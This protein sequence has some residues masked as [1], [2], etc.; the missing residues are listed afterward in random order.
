M[1]IERKNLVVVGLAIIIL[2]VPIAIYVFSFRDFGISRDNEDWANFGSYLAGTYTL[3]ASLA[4]VAT[5]L[6][7]LYQHYGQKDQQDRLSLAQ[8]EIINFQKYQAHYQQ[9]LQLIESVEQDERYCV[10]IINKSALYKEL[11]PE[12]S[13]AECSYVINL[14]DKDD[15]YL[16][17]DIK[18][19][20]PRLKEMFRSVEVS[21]NQAEQIVDSLSRLYDTFYLKLDRPEQ[22][23]DIVFHVDN[24]SRHIILNTDNLKEVSS[25]LWAVLDVLF[26]FSDN[27]APEDITY[28]VG[29]SFTKNSMELYKKHI[30][31]ASHGYILIDSEK[32]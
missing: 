2:L 27:T 4:S 7:V 18:L 22:K 15:S 8:L 21:V 17:N 16:L 11:F 12:N 25:N 14:D 28:Q 1:K 5:L 32:S 23:N 13:F 19:S 26:H 20:A 30:K 29:S 24:S 6:F 3:L 10:S 9:F 31:D